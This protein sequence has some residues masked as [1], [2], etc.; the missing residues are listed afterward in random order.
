[1][2]V[3]T[4]G[5]VD[6]G[7]TLLIRTL[8]GVDTDRLPDEKKRGLTI[9]IGFAYL[10][11]TGH[12]EPIGFIDVPGHEKFI[13]NMVCGVAGIDYALFVIAADDF[14]N[15]LPKRHFLSF[16]SSFAPKEV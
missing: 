3:A 8:T 11:L 2:I 16:L 7:K 5:H 14:D 12:D 4:A 15:F 1:M 13:R 6:H 10:P 9:D